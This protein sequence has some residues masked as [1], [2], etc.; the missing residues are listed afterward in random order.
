MVSSPSDITWKKLTKRSPCIYACIHT[1]QFYCI[2]IWCGYLCPP[3]KI[4]WK[5]YS[6]LDIS[7]GKCNKT[8]WACFIH[9]SLEQNSPSWSS[10]NKTPKKKNHWEIWVQDCHLSPKCKNGNNDNLTK[11]QRDFF[12][13]SRLYAVTVFVYRSNNYYPEEAWQIEIVS[14][15]GVNCKVPNYLTNVLILWQARRH[16]IDTYQGRWNRFWQAEN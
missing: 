5:K 6:L 2:S 9:I 10:D 11:I 13:E 12:F 15:I 14:H 7:N 1:T 4:S 8:E 16:S 3:R